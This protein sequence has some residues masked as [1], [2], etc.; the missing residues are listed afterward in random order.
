MQE[1]EGG[2]QVKGEPLLEGQRD[3]GYQMPVEYTWDACR[4]DTSV[5]RLPSH[6]HPPEFLRTESLMPGSAAVLKI[7]ITDS[8]FQ[9]GLSVLNPVIMK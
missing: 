3:P 9:L 8:S 5:P 1:D 4:G 7:S 2:A 6:H